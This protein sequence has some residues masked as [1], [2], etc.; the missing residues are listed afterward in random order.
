MDDKLQRIA[1]SDLLMLRNVP[2]GEFHSHPTSP[3]D[4][5]SRPG[6]RTT[7]ADDANACPHCAGAG[8]YTQAVRFGHPDFGVLFPCACKH[9]ERAQRQTQQQAARLKHLMNIAGRYADAT[10]HHFRAA[11]CA[12]T[13]RRRPAAAGCGV[14]LIP[15]ALGVMR[16]PVQT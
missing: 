9:Q 3:P 8:Y 15:Y 14:S 16:R 6:S 10:F 5:A 7:P 4:G 2:V 12:R 11:G 13:R 1:P